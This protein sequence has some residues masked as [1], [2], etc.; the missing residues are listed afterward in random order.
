MLHGMGIATGVDL[1]AVAETSRTVAGHLGLQLPSRY[2]EAG[3]EPPPGS[4]A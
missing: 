1:T 3:P 4:R 2:L